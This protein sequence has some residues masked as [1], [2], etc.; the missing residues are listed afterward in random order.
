MNGNLQ[1]VSR[2]FIVGMPEQETVSGAQS[3]CP[4]APFV[5]PIPSIDSRGN[6]TFIGWLY[7]EPTFGWPNTTPDNSSHHS[8]LD[9]WASPGTPVMAQAAGTIVKVET[10]HSGTLKPTIKYPDIT[11]VGNDGRQTKGDVY[12]YTDNLVSGKIGNEEINIS[13][14]FD[15][16]YSSVS[17]GSVIGFVGEAYAFAI[18]GQQ[19]IHWSISPKPGTDQNPIPN[20]EFEALQLDPTSFLTPAGKSLN[21]RGQRT[22]ITETLSWWCTSG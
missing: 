2:R 1:E 14:K 16:G 21:A 10:G 17:A 13:N 4:G 3:R 5:F 19:H 6:T 20:A 8:G 15:S 18:K 11:Y 9:F 7:K 12:V 22:W